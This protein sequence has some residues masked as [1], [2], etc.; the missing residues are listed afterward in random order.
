MGPMTSRPLPATP[1]NEPVY[2]EVDMD[3]EA[4][5]EPPRDLGAVA[6]RAAEHVVDRLEIFEH[7]HILRSLRER[8]NQLEIER[9]SMAEQFQRRI[10]HLEDELRTAQEAF[11]DLEDRVDAVED[12]SDQVATLRD[13]KLGPMER[14]LDFVAGT[15]IPAI[16]ERLRELERI[17]QERKNAEAQRCSQQL[18]VE[19]NLRSLQL[20][21][22]EQRLHHNTDKYLISI[23]VVLC[24]VL[25]T[26][27]WKSTLLQN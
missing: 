20:Q 27:V 12:L 14:R 22:D 19:N 23:L 9:A 5:L 11:H 10:S 13:R 4:P 15:R 2:S 8:I 25:L 1:T 6:R 3:E 7:S 21:M 24:A 26:F 18:I 17:D 16:M